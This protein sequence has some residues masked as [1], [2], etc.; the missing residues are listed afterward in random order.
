VSVEDRE[1]QALDPPQRRQQTLDALRRLLLRESRVQPLVI[2]CENLQWI[3]TE[4]QA[5]L[6]SL[7]DCLSTARILLLVNYR[8]EYQ[9]T[10][11]RK[12][13][14]TQLRLDPLPPASAQTLLQALLGDDSG[15]APLKRILVE[16]TAG[17]PFFLEE[18]VRTLVESQ[19]LVG[20]LGAYRLARPLSTIQV[21]ATVQAV[22][23][24]RMDRLPPEDK[25]LLQ[26][27]AV[28]GKDV[29]FPL[30]HAIVELP[31]ESLRAA[32]THLQA[33]EFLYEASLFPELEYMFKHAL[34]QEVAYGGLLQERRRTLHARVVEA[35]EQLYPDRIGAHVERLAYHALRGE[36]W[37]KALRYCRQ[38]GAKGAARSAHREAV[39]CFE[40]ALLALQHLPERQDTREQAIDLRF[41]LRNALLPLGEHGQI[42]EHLRAA[43]TL[44]EVLRDERRLGQACAYMAEYFRMTG[45]A[46]HAVESGERALTLAT[47]LG[48]STLQVMATFYVGTAYQALGTYRR[49]VDCFRR[50]VAALTGERSRERFGMTGLPAVMSRTWLVS[51]LADLG[52][53]D[54]GTA[55]GE[56][57]V[58]MAEAVEH[59]F[60]LTQAYFALGT[61]S[62]RKGD[63]SKAIPVL[64]RGLDV[65]QTA[66]IL[67]WLP[68]GASALGYAYSLA[69]RVTEALPLLQQA[70]AQNTTRG[71]SAGHARWV[72]YLSEAYLLAGHIDE[73]SRLAHRALTF[74][75]DV[76]ARGNEAYALRLLGEIQAHQDPTAAEAAE[77][78]YQQALA[79]AD[80][81]GMSPLLA[82]CHLGLGSL[83]TKMGRLAPARAELS[84][85]IERF[86]AMEMTFWLPRAEAMRAHTA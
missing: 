28:I 86:E 79:L 38:A 50:N 40:Q 37:E 42:Y 60:S 5:F 77:T 23:A 27:A 54:E 19:V 11:A 66:N 4:T 85:A 74:A 22:L 39:E 17:N 36:G 63:L 57:A 76:K 67:T 26:T 78:A 10:W 15:L 71:L 18:S 35:I 32:L 16:R 33:A 80:E 56:E 59:A 44:A 48:D 12:P 9:H 25:T 2:V 31:E 1:W 61:L 6:D 62:L 51:C 34:T 55:R 13:Y 41:S 49:A 30:L 82:H 68:P 14:Y 24:A 65:C 29:P 64:E 21:P 52:A 83:Y 69:G 70:A 8:L 81:L 53:F 20:E 58:G 73:A 84:T 43:Q 45:N 72:T 7:V 75:R 46:A 47:A 3:D